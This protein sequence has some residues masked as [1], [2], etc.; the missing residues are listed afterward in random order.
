ML[1][2]ASST[3]KVHEGASLREQ[4][5]VAVKSVSDPIRDLHFS[6]ISL[7]APGDGP[8][9]DE[10]LRHVIAHPREYYMC[11]GCGDGPWHRS[12]AGTRN[13]SLALGPCCTGAD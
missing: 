5:V 2:P 8:L 3:I 4:A 9:T 12:W 1:Q 11:T 7:D 10:G 13:R 6:S